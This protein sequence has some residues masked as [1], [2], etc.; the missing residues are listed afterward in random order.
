MSID[1]RLKNIEIGL[2]CFKSIFSH[3]RTGYQ[4]G[5][6]TAKISVRPDSLS[7]LVVT[8]TLIQCT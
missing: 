1:L 2:L 4:K 7:F 3:V 5:K 6:V 8:N